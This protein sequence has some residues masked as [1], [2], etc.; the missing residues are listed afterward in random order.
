MKET[1]LGRLYPITIHPY[2]PHWPQWFAEEATQLS[3]L[4]GPRFSPIEHIGSTAVPGLAAKP[5]IDILVAL[6][7]DV[8]TSAVK[9]I[10]THLDYIYMQE[11]TRHLMFVKGYT[12]NGLAEKSFHIHMGAVTQEWLWDRLHFRDYLRGHPQEAARY[13]ALKVRLAEEFHY[14]RERY[15]QAKAE[16]IQAITQRAK[17]HAAS[18]KNG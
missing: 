11:Q 10:L 5:T 1:E 16:Y 13:Q 6:P 18:S 14:N 8:D 3:H 17:E 9:S 7:P 12:P 2:N 15:T 4:L